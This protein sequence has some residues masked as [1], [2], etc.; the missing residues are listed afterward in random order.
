MP[1]REGPPSRCPY[2]AALTAVV[3]SG[4]FLSLG[5]SGLAAAPELQESDLDAESRELDRQLQNTRAHRRGTA[6]GC[7]R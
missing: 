6:P 4:G 7:R 5:D 1:R 2:R 3:V